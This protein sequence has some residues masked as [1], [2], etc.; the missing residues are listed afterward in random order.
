MNTPAVVPY[1]VHLQSIRNMRKQITKLREVLL[2]ARH[3]ITPTG[4]DT[5]SD[6]AL[7]AIDK[8]LRETT[9]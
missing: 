5:K 3:C 1:S 6:R 9:P 4:Q 8:I 7:K 2:D